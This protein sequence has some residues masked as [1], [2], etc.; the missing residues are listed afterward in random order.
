MANIPVLVVPTCLLVDDIGV[1]NFDEVGNVVPA[2]V[3]STRDAVSTGADFTTI[4]M[5]PRCKH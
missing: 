3:M 2:V 4:A 5:Q 1:K